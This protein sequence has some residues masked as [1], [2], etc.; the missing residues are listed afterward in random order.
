M[1]VLR[2]CLSF[3][4]S[5][6][7]TRPPNKRQN[8]SARSR[9]HGAYGQNAEKNANDNHECHPGPPRAGD[10]VKVCFL[11]SRPAFTPVPRSH[12]DQQVNREFRCQKSE[13]CLGHTTR[14]PPLPESQ[15]G[16]GEGTDRQ[17]WRHAG[18]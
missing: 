12:A 9:R 5:S 1:L 11:P 10:A 6:L 14:L 7:G 16:E 18:G 15:W 2:A 4:P 13:G 17:G 8:P 3:T